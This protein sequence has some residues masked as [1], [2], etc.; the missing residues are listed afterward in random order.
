MVYNNC[1]KIVRIFYKIYTT[2]VKDDM[3][4]IIRDHFYKIENC[5][6]SLLVLTYK[7][8]KE[9]SNSKAQKEWRNTMLL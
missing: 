6:D 1:I 4:P 8:Y 2:Y 7:Q 9:S 5:Y 3:M